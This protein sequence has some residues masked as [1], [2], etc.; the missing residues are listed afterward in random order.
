M[1]QNRKIRSIG[2]VVAFAIVAAIAALDFYLLIVAAI[3][4]VF[5]TI[6]LAIAR[7]KVEGFWKGLKFFITQILFGW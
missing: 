7:G 4:F 1:K 5:L 6:F 2:L 3:L